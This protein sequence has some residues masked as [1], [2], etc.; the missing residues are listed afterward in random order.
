MK[1]KSSSQKKVSVSKPAVRKMA[2]G[3]TKNGAVAKVAAMSLQDSAVTVDIETIIIR[4]QR[5]FNYRLPLMFS[6]ATSG[7]GQFDSVMYQTSLTATDCP[8]AVIQEDGNYKTEQRCAW[9]IYVPDDGYQT[10]IN[11][12]LTGQLRG[13][14][15]TGGASVNG[16]WGAPEL[17]S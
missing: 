12:T 7:A 16:F 17:I 4:I 15:W 8:D 6:Q 9:I 1:K 2:A 14:G 13:T 10:A 5:G 3:Q 11:V